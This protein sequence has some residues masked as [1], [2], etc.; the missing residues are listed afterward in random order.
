MSP[1]PLDVLQE[2]IL[3]FFGDLFK[4]THLIEG[5]QEAYLVLHSSGFGLRFCFFQKGSSTLEIVAEHREIAGSNMPE[6]RVGKCFFL[7]CLQHPLG[8]EILGHHPMCIRVVSLIGSHNHPLVIIGVGF[9]LYSIDI[10]SKKE[11]H[12]WR[13]RL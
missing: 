4:A 7:C 6:V 1:E 10:A 3:P 11:I 8:I 5:L 9:I 2:L 12:I 13:A